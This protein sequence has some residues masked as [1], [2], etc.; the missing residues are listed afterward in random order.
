LVDSLGTERI[1][2]ELV[3]VGQRSLE[4]YRGI[5]RDALL[6]ELRATSRDLRGARILNL[7]ATPYGGGVSEL[8][9]STVPLLDDLGVV[10]HWRLIRGD[11]A[12]FDVTKAIHNAMQGAARTLS[13]REKATYL[14]NARVNSAAFSEEYDFV[15]VHDPQPAAILSMHGKGS[16][17]WVWRCHID[18]SAPNGPVWDF[19][20]PFLSDF[21]AAIFTMAQFVPPDLPIEHREIIPPAIDPRSPKNMPLADETARQ[22]LEWLG[23]RVDRPLIA[24]VSRFDP[25]KDPM[26]VIAAYRLAREQIA[27]LQLVLAGSMAMDDPEGWALYRKIREETKDDR[28]VHVLTNLVGVGNIEINALQKLSS[29]VVQKSL[30]EG[31]GLVVSESLWK[32]TPVVAGRAGGIPL[33]MADGVGGVLVDSVEECARALV[34]MLRDSPRARALGASGRERV[35]DHFLIPRLVLSELSLMHQLQLARPAVRAVDWSHR[36]PV[37][38]MALAETPTISMT[39]GGVTYGFCSDRCRSLFTDSPDRYITSMGHV[40][41]LTVH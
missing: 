8:L 6:D 4:S 21:D 39:I 31:F 15:F 2:L 26:G 13:D 10:A 36:D 34:S 14:A 3:D 9:R 30:R 32:G 17:R 19:L 41:P 25:W 24:Q 11:D 18:T 37:C 29:V 27:D 12:F 23:I 38:G 16:A 35:R 20:R 1:V 5:V 33:Q 40:E 7:N 28:L 22:V